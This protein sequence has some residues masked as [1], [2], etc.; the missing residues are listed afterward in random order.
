MAYR[1][2]E[3]TT[4]TRLSTIDSGFLLTESAHSPK[5]VGALMIFELPAGKGSAWLRRLLAEMKRTPPGFPFNQRIRRLAGPVYEMEPDDAFDIE[6]HVRH[7]MLPRPG[8]GAQL[9]EL[10]AQLHATL[11]DR[12]RPLWEFHLIEGLQGRRFALYVKLHH[13]IGDG[14]TFGRWIDDSTTTAPRDTSVRPI[15][16][17]PEAVP[18]GDS[19]GVSYL[20]MAEDAIKTLGGGVR[21]A[22]GIGAISARMVQRRLFGH[23]EHVALP[24]SAPRTSLNVPT[25]S[26]RSVAFTSWPL[27]DLR[28]VGKARGATINDVVMTMCDMAISHYFEQHGTAPRGS[29]V[30]YMPVNVRD[31][32]ACGDGNLLTLLQ[33][34]LASTHNDPLSS[35]AEVRESIHSAREV[36]SGTSR[37]A[38]QYYSMMVALA[39]QAE[40]ILGLGRFLP[41]VNNLVI[42]NVSGSRVKRYLKGAEAVGMYPVSTLPP[43]TALN[44]TCCSYAG[45]LYF[46]LTAGRSAVPDLPLLIEY[47]HEAFGQLALATGTAPTATRPARKSA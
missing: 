4:M 15:W 5:H 19:D 8:T 21:T 45:T 35:L 36:F 23:D 16:D 7:T 29:L 32:E 39:A 41:P 33:V 9:D 27:E 12:D 31:A 18:E 3:P 24:L 14:I 30:A 28:A 42:S 11:L 25:G 13:A 10:V 1:I 26:A 22:L 47:L 38:V 40:E 43:L 44:V 2:F 6:Y 37:P 46:G 20:Q 34:K 17:R